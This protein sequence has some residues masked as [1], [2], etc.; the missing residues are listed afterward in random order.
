MIDGNQTHLIDEV[1]LLHWLTKAQTQPAVMRL[2]SRSVNFDPFIRIW[3]VAFHGGRPM[4]HHSRASY[5]GDKAELA[6]VP[7]KQ[8]WA[9]TAASVQLRQ[10]QSFACEY[11]NLILRYPGWPQQAKKISSI[12]STKPSNNVHRAGHFPLLP[13]AV[14][15]N[16]HL[17]SECALVIGKTL[18]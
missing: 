7:G 9:G 14:C 3:S 16:L 10:H 12:C 18:Q 2:Q 8:S 11:V 13:Q 4:P 1:D 5:I 17:G 6:A 15:E